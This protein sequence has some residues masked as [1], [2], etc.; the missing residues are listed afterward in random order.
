M[1]RR[2]LAAGCCAGSLAGYH[3]RSLGGFFLEFWGLA[4]SDAGSM[5]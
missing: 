2:E 4:A 5:E 3:G 1:G